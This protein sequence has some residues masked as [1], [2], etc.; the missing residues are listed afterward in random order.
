MFQQVREPSNVLERVYK[1]LLLRLWWVRRV[2]KGINVRV[3]KG[4][5]WVRG[6]GITNTN[7][8]KGKS[9][10]SYQEPKKKKVFE[11]SVEIGG[12]CRV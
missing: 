4:D 6:W 10:K 3:V 5:G 8:G 2:I 12:Q 1:L 9:A 11:Q 7:V